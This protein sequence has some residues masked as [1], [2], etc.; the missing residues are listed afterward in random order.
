MLAMAKY[1]FFKLVV[2]TEPVFKEISAA[3]IL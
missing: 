1:I 2:Y 3:Y